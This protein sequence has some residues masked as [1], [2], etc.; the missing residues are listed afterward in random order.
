[1]A[2][3]GDCD[4]GSRLP[5]R[6]PFNDCPSGTEVSLEE[7]PNTS[8]RQQWTRSPRWPQPAGLF[9]GRSHRPATHGAANKPVT[10]VFKLKL[11]PSGRR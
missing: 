8:E 1:M 3:A 5:L 2:T 11:A 4:T 6:Y 10:K 9:L 7:R